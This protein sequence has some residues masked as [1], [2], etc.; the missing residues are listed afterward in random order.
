MFPLLTPKI[1]YYLKLEYLVTDN[2]AYLSLYKYISVEHVLT[3]NPKENSEWYKTF[4]EERK[5]RTN[6]LANLVLISKKRIAH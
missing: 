2:T 6:K 4:T 1:L 3:Q 5:Q